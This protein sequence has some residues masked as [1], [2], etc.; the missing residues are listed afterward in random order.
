MKRDPSETINFYKSRD[1]SPYLFHFVKGNTPLQVLKQILKENALKSDKHEFICYTESPLRVMKDVLDYFQ[2]FKGKTGCCPMFELY[3]IGLKK[4]D[5]FEKYGARPVIYGPL[6]DKNHMDGKLLW[7]F[8]LL[9]FENAN[10][11]WQR[12]WRTKGK[13][14][15]LPEDNEDVI[16]ICRYEKEVESLKELY[17]HP[18][19]SFEYVEKAHASDYNAESYAILQLMSNFEIECYKQEGEEL[20]KTYGK[21]RNCKIHNIPDF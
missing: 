1:I 4:K 18:C 14:F 10:F 21:G 20:K 11:S 6:E 2:T 15:E 7:R 3:G 9:D 12:E 17:G 13:F 8:E 19:I 16:I 5:M